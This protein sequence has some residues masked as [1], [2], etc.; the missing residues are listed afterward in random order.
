[1]LKA[2]VASAIEKQAQALHQ[3][4]AAS[5]DPREIVLLQAKYVIEECRV[6]YDRAMQKLHEMD[7]DLRNDRLEAIM[8]RSE[9]ASWLALLVALASLVV[10][11]VAWSR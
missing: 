4:E 9:I 7:D 10:S 5:N 2:A 6:N 8:L 11:M 1:M 3:M